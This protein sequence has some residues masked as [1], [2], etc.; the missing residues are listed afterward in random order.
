MKINFDNYEYDG[1]W[2][3]NETVTFNG[4]Q[5]YVDV[6]IDGYDEIVIPESSKNA[7]LNFLDKLNSYIPKIQEAVFEYYCELRD[8]LGYDVEV[9]DDYPDL[10]NSE[11][12]LN[13]ITLI[14]ITVPDQDDYDED[15]ISLVF[16]CT[17]EVEHGLGIC[18]IGDDINEVGFQDVAL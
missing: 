15:A 18:F 7:L 8:R 3:G 13:M 1:A 12:I 17:W 4:Q 10:S 9:N 5:F 11:E 6:Q 16:D 14:G 2:F